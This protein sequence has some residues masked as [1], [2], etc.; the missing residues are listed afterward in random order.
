MAFHT[1]NT[2]RKLRE[3]DSKGFELFWKQV[4][5]GAD[6]LELEEAKLKRKRKMPKTLVDFFGFGNTLNYTP[7]LTVDMYYKSVYLDALDN[8]INFISD[9]F[10][11]EDF[12]IIIM[13]EKAVLN[14]ILQKDIDHELE[15]LH[16]N[17]DD[18][19]DM[20]AFKTQISYLSARMGESA[21]ESTTFM[22]VVSFVREMP[23]ASRSIMSSVVTMLKLILVQPSTNASSERCFSNLRRIKS[24]LRSRTGQARLNHLMLMSIY[25]EELD[26]LSLDDIVEEFIMNNPDARRCIFG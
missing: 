12:K 10:D 7:D 21:T 18:T 16:K 13:M 19:L 2:L 1:R 14:G 24:Y 5:D 4:T 25:R 17:Y 9:K 8:I 15:Y 23:E 11:Q 26:N 22:D 20:D 3:D 6:Q